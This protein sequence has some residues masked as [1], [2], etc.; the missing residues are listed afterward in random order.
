[1]SDKRQKT[2]RLLAFLMEEKGETLN[3]VGEGSEA[4][5]ATSPP[6]SPAI[7]KPLFEVPRA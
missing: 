6:E 7:M 5:A 2:Q 3:P 1:M 4:P